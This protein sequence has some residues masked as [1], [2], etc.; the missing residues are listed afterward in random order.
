MKFIDWV[1]SHPRVVLAMTMALAALGFYSFKSLPLNLFPDTNRPVVSVVTRWP[2][3]AADDVATQVTHP[4]EVRM[5]SIDGVRR[6]TSTS[7]DQVSAI[8]VEFEY[9]NDVSLAATDVANELPRVRSSLPPGA[10]DPLLFKITEAA[11][12]VA[13]LAIKASVEGQLSEELVRRISENALRDALLSI[14][15]V[16]EAEVFGGRSLQVS[17][18]LDRNKL[19]AHGL[20]PK[21]VAT[22][23]LHTNVSIPSGLVHTSEADGDQLRILLTTKSLAKNPSDIAD[24]LVPLAGGDFVRTA[25]LGKVYWSHPDETSLYRGNGSPAIAISLLRGDKGHADQVLASISTELPKIR[26]AFPELNI[27]IADSQGRLIDLTVDNMLSSLRDALIMTMIVLLLFLGNTR[28]ALVAALSLPLTYL[29]T[30]IGMRAFGFEFNMVTLTAIIIAVGL[31]ADDAVVVIENVERH[32]RTLGEK[33]VVAATRGTKE[34]LLADTAGTISTVIVIVPIM[35][36]GGYVQT[37]LRPLSLTLAIALFSSLFVSL[38]IIPLVAAWVLHPGARDPLKWIY[39][40]VD[41]LITDPLRHGF[42]ALV[43]W[44]VNHRL[45]TLVGF[46]VMFVLSARMMPSIGR[47]LMP[48]MD[49]GVIRVNFEAEADSD[50]GNMSRIAAAIEA[51]VGEVIPSEW[52]ISSSNVVGSEPSVKSFGAAR[53]LQQGTLT[54]NLVDRFQRDEGQASIEQRLRER[55]LRV[56]RLISISVS[57][58]GATPLSS[59][60]GN[61][62]VML[63]GPDPAVLDQLGNEVFDRLSRVP[64]LSAIERTWRSNSTRWDLDVNSSLARRYG[65][66]SSS[67]SG[68]VAQAVAGTPASLLRIPGEDPIPV[69]ARLAPDQRRDPKDIERLNLRTPTGAFVPLASVASLHVSTVPNAE[70]HQALIPT[71]D[72]IGYRRDVDIAHLQ[73]AVDKSLVGLTLPRG[74]SIS[75][76][77]ESKQMNESFGRLGKSLIFGLALLLLMLIITFRSFFDPVAIMATL[78]LALIGASWAMMLAGKH[79]CL[80]SFMGMILLMGIVVNNGILLIDFAKAELAKGSELSE[81]LIQAVHLRTR[82]ILITASASAVG[83]IPVALEWAVGIERL[84]PLAVVAI[85]G[86]LTGTVLTLMVVPVLFHALESMRQRFATASH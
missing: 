8:A 46:A 65:L 51:G 57:A 72:I 7:R 73:Q 77:G 2:G 25:D 66:D 78:P 70:T 45:L 52:L 83:M 12:P 28:A 61:I 69:L 24:I 21:D 49:T 60:R 47:E 19:E 81:A 31:L 48:I 5:S 34:I 9:G 74:Y 13:V 30:F 71:L 50:L 6:V 26:A 38:T 4:I 3:A 10:Q 58:F 41:K 40:L 39:R 56:P 35:F 64:G 75:Q 15:G 18:D 62:D 32:L 85:G 54:L 59:L 86:L 79:G 17:V 37:V 16:S 84:S 53:R 20:T 80:P 67:I 14:P 27:E 36:I 44:G 29:M 23:L 43:A 63:S 68:Q 33:G 11:N 55:L 1:L 42:G 22:A 82:P 76:E